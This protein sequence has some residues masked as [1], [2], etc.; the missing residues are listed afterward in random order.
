MLNLS[1]S[2]VKRGVASVEALWL[3]FTVQM[4]QDKPASVQLMVTY[5]PI[6]PSFQS[7]MKCHFLIH[8]PAKQLQGAFSLPLLIAF[9]YPRYSRE[10]LV[11][12]ALTYTCH[13]PP[14]N[15]QCR[16]AGCRMCSIL[17]TTN[18]FTSHKTRQTFKMK[19]TAAI[20]HLINYRRWGFNM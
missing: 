11:L 16:G 15:Q 7:I 1:N 5:H 18:E 3:L 14:G 10:L 4:N 17:M 19:M 13:E 8:H 9:H 20:V 12:A 6:V 2:K